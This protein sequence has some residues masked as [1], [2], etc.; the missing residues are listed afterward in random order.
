MKISH[1][2]IRNYRSIES[3]EVDISLSLTP[4]V[5]SLIVPTRYDKT[6]QHHLP[7]LTSST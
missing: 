1:I 2:T 6:Y 7:G 4:I 5:G 3:L